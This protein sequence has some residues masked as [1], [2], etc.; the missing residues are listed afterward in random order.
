MRRTPTHRVSD[1]PQNAE[2]DN[3]QE[4]GGATSRKRQPRWAVGKHNIG[5]AV[6]E[7]R[8]SSTVPG[9]AACEYPY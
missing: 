7:V 4:Q 5:G 1:C 9:L 8:W 6:L 2:D 3:R